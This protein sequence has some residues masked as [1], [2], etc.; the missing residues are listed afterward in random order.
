MWPCTV[1][2]YLFCF[3]E[4]LRKK[5]IIHERKLDKAWIELWLHPELKLDLA[6]WNETL[7]KNG[8]RHRSQNSSTITCRISMKKSSF[9]SLCSNGAS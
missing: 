1:Q 2:N 3:L 8:T 4:E 6:L 5:G 9:S 7:Y